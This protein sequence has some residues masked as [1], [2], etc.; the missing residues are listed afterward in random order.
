[1]IWLSSYFSFLQP[2][3]AS[4]IAVLIFPLGFLISSISSKKFSF[5]ILQISNAWFGIV[6]IIIS[7]TIFIELLNL[8][9]PFNFLVNGL[10]I[11]ALVL[12][13]IIFS[14]I[15]R[16][17]WKTKNI[18]IMSKKVKKEM[19]IV[20]LSDV[21]AYGI[22]APKLMR[23]VFNKAIK[24]NPDVIVLTGD[25][26]DVPKK[27]PLNTFKLLDDIKIPI[28][29]ELGN[30]ES[31]VGL[32]YVRQLVKG[33]SVTLLENKVKIVKGVSFVGI[34]DSSDKTN[35]EKILPGLKKNNSLFQVL[36]YH[37]PI[38]YDV[39][40]ENNFDL[41]LSGHTHAGQFFPLPLILWLK[42]KYMLGTH[43]IKNMILHISSGSG[44][45][46]WPLRFG[47]FQEITVIKLLPEE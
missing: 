39:A 5:Y 3:S 30:H 31:Y 37:Q 25:I 8:I 41:M 23:F 47:S 14:I 40:Q 45:F 38:E 29:Y 20:Q 17:T 36:L 6:L 22:F 21:H 26:V 16:V 46:S 35:L 43:K 32:D 12:I 18:T 10:F 13:L 33:T 9:I 28:L 42:Y 2:L 15:G 27:P 7:S 44:A 4:T 1:M 24:E 11:L 19:T 34:S